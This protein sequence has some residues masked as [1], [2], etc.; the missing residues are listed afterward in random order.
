MRGASSKYFFDDQGQILKQV[1]ALNRNVFYSY[2]NKLHL[3]R[4]TDPA[5][6]VYSYSYDSRGNIIE[7]I[8][9][10]MP[11]PK[12]MGACMNPSFPSVSGRTI[13]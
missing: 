12:M 5:G 9:P 2:D 3:T 6:Q 1:D 4:V 13:V 10:P 7:S 8:D 11:G